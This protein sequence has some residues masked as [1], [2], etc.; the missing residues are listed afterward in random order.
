M[1]RVGVMFM[2]ILAF[3]VFSV[4]VAN[5]EDGKPMGLLLEGNVSG[6]SGKF[7]GGADRFVTLSGKEVT[8][9]SVEATLS[10]CKAFEGSEKDT[11]LCESQITLHGVKQ[12]KVACRSE[13]EAGLK[14]AVETVLVAADLH[15][16]AGE[17]AAKALVP[18]G[19]GKV[20]GQSPTESSEELLVNCGG[21]KDRIK[22]VLSCEV[23]P[24]LV[25]IPVTQE[26]TISCKV[27]A[28]HDQEVVKCVVLCEWLTEHP[29]EANL[30]AGFEDAGIERTSKGTLNKD[31]FI[32]D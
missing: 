7:K 14:D 29:F 6:L 18:L 15:L 3:E 22:G 26:I 28:S 1:K 31:I 17:T 10:G 8:D 24:G 13:S 23:S 32:D 11:N 27:T 2:A 12:G 4:A 5:A 25:N 19:L 16:A 20:L 9:I 21:V 30:G